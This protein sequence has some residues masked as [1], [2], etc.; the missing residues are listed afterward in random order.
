MV[1]NISHYTLTF[2]LIRE[3]NLKM[4]IIPKEI[5]SQTYR[6]SLQLWLTHKAKHGSLYCL[7]ACVPACVYLLSFRPPL[8]GLKHESTTLL[9][10]DSFVGIKTMRSRKQ[11]LDACTWKK[12][13]LNSKDYINLI[14]LTVTTDNR[15]QLRRFIKE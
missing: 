5:I 12:E 9:G 2:A 7:C 8:W 15:R 10:L 11:K 3:W 1:R 13:Y 14:K 6:L 4:E